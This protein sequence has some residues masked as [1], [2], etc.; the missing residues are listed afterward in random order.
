MTKTLYI[1]LGGLGT[2]VVSKIKSQQSGIFNSVNRYI[3]IDRCRYDCF[4]C[5]EKDDTPF[6]SVG[7]D[8]SL[9]YYIDN[10]KPTFNI[11]EWFPIEPIFIRYVDEHI[12]MTRAAGRL[13]FL[14]AME[15]RILN[16]IIDLL[17]EMIASSDKDDRFQ[18]VIVTSL[19]GGTGSGAFI[20]LALWIRKQLSKNYCIDFCIDGLFVGPE[21]FINSFRDVGDYSDECDVLRGNTYAALKELDVINEIIQGKAPEKFFNNMSLDGLLNRSGVQNDSGLVYDSIYIYDLFENVSDTCGSFYEY[22][23][24]ISRLL[25]SQFN[26]VATD[27]GVQIERYINKS[28]ILKNAYI[29]MCNRAKELIDYTPHIDKRWMKLFED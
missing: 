20:Q 4:Y 12:E 23:N 11:E 17:D 2:R 7:L 6:I 5:S 29:S 15:S 13:A 27:I 14:Q 28:A 25:H 18:V 9:R 16:P 21:V 10:L 8:K 24:D 22:V 26:S 3:L 1:G 19:A